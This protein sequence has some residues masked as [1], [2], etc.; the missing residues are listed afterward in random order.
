MSPFFSCFK[1]LK[2]IGCFLL[3]VATAAGALFFIGD[4]A[5][6]HK[7]AGENDL[8]IVFQVVDAVDNRPLKDATV[9]VVL[10]DYNLCR[11]NEPLPFKLATDSSGHA[12]HIAHDCLCFGTKRSW[13]FGQLDT[14]SIHVPGWYVKVEADGYVPTALF[15]LDTPENQKK[16]RIDNGIAILR[17][18]VALERRETS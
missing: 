14:F 17:L 4:P 11:N 6:Y 10:E 12:K 5:L 2:I 15:F 3:I 18:A 16:V 9:E 8:E 13:L 7:W 1:G